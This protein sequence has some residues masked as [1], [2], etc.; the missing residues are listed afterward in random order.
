MERLGEFPHPGRPAPPPRPRRLCRAALLSISLA[1]GSVASVSAAGAANAPIRWT[2]VRPPTSPSART[3]PSLAADP[4]SE[5]VV[6]FGGSTHFGTT[7]LAE[8]WTWDGASWTEQH[9]PTSP[10]AR[11]GAMIA[12]DPRSGHV[13]LFGGFGPLGNGFNGYLGDTWT[14]RGDAW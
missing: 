11:E 7:Y 2:E 3:G 1:I 10:S 8:T 9:P 4:A 5:K 13:V 14:W 6:L 12:T